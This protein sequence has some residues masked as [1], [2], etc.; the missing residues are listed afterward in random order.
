MSDN[1]FVIT[2]LFLIYILYYY[3]FSNQFLHYQDRL[4]QY[5]TKPYVMSWYMYHYEHLYMY[6]VHVVLYQ[7]ICNVIVH[8]SL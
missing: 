1:T 3:L 2:L 6:D 4:I 5:Y 8:A 7:T